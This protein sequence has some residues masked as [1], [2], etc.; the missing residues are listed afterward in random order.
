MIRKSLKAGG[1]ALML[2]VTAPFA[3]AHTHVTPDTA[4]DMNAGMSGDMTMDMGAMM[5]PDAAPPTGIMGGM[6]PA[7]GRLIPSLGFMHMEMD[8]NRAGTDRVS[9]AQVL[10]QFPVAPLAMEMGMTMFG[11]MYGVTDDVSVMA[12]VPY[13][14][15]SMP[16]L[17]RTG[18][19]FRTASR[20]WGDVSVLANWRVWQQGT[21]ELGLSA[22]LALPTGSTDE[23]DATPMGPNQVLPYPMQ[24]GSGTFDLL[25]AIT[26]KARTGDLSWGAQA[27]GRIR[28]GENDENYSLG[29][30]YSLSVWAARRWSNAVSTSI[31]LTGAAIGDIDGADARLNPAIVPTAVAGLRAGETLD[32]GLGLNFLVRSGPAKGTRLTVEA[33]APIHQRLDGPQVERDYTVAARISKMF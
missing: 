13:V 24:I 32:L 9:T 29:D 1:I 31:R 20:G 33:G 16:H 23:R 4:M 14:E 26:Y 30:V 7:R 8:G 11:L 12:M 22:G 27:R 21:Q 28:L 18:V 10:A 15:K 5:R 25:P 3:L 19:R 6:F 2:T 17:T